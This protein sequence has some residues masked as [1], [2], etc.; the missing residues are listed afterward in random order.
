M[1]IVTPICSRQSTSD[2][3]W[4]R[5]KSFSATLKSTSASKEL[6]RIS[7]IIGIDISDPVFDSAESKRRI[8]EIFEPVSTVFVMLDKSLSGKVCLIWNHLAHYAL[9]SLQYDLFVLL[10]DDIEFKTRNWS[11]KIEQRF[12]DLAHERS[13]PLGATCVAFHDQSFPG[14]PTFPVVHAY[15]LKVFD[16]L[17]L[18]SAFVNQDGDPFLFE[19]YRRYG[20]SC[21][22]EDVHH[23]G[24]RGRSV[25]ETTGS[26]Q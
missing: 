4:T 13:M 1:G 15:H 18:P 11:S 12:R 10:G 16:G 21:I 5:L 3:C 6:G 24:E 26:I 14:F 23:W 17:L 8:T 25:F 19:L 9:E 20:T 22:L 7:I 2:N